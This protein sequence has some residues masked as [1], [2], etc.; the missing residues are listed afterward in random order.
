MANLFARIKD[1]ISADMHDL[2]DQK[3]E[4]N[5]MSLLNRY[6]REGEREAEKVRRLVERQHCLK[7]EFT[8]EYQEALEKATKR[9]YQSEIAQKA[10]EESLYEFAIKEKEAFLIRSERLKGA[11]DEAVGELEK[12]EQ[13]YESMK[14]KLKEMH[15]K[16][17]EMMGREN[18]ARANYTINSVMD[19]SNE[20]ACSRFNDIEMYLNNLEQKVNSAYFKETFDSKISQ[21]ERKLAKGEKGETLSSK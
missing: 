7:D 19:Q 14:Y 5:P 17:M 6:L 13:Q 9:K 16:R 20:K 3:E 12:L 8:R 18:I 21:L 1:S 11:R 2:L 15:L 4:K 10:G